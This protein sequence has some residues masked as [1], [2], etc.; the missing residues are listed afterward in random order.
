M[1]EKK[2]M[3]LKI[4]C[5]MVAGI[6]F[7][8]VFQEGAQAVRILG[9]IFLRMIQMAIV[10]LIL[11]QIIE[12][13]GGLNPKELGKLGVKTVMIFSVSSYLAAAFGI[14]MG[15]MLK[16]GLGL[17]MTQTTIQQSSANQLL[18]LNET[19]LGF[20]PKNIFQSMAE[21]NIVQ[22]IVF[23]LLFGIALSYSRLEGKGE[24][25]YEG[26]KHLNAIIIKMIYLVMRLAPLGIFSLVAS[27]IGELGLEVILPLVK[28]LLVYGVATFLFLGLWFI[29][30]SLYTKIKVLN[31]IKG[32]TQ[33]S[34]M[35]LATTSSAV[36]LPTAMK[37]ASEKLRISERINKL[38]LPLGMSLNSNGSA[39]HM[40]I[41]VVTISQFWDV[42]Y[43]I[44]TYFYIAGLAMILSLAN[45]VVPGA[46]LVS[47][48]IILPQM[49]L[50]L[51][52]IA[53]F[54]GVEWFVG[55]L[56]TILNVDSDVFTALLVAKSEN[57]IAQTS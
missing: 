56:R 13:V 28:Y 51:E 4:M 17:Q 5:S 11:G 14:F 29:V 35:A 7:G 37:D 43:S 8:S 33:M 10:P 49:N 6:F 54:A 38:V 45:A 42:E 52:S 9:D 22:I 57:E 46:G 44:A 21:G 1:S 39:M 48:A 18:S 53:F 40:A 3:T 47:L 19:V 41:T 15:V 32:M 12:S 31:L 36:T 55:M 24:S 34:F 27:T 16:P 50:P 2:S 20:F 26:I 30:A 23:A 25:I